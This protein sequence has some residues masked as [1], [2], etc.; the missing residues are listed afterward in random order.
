MVDYDVIFCQILKK[1]TLLDKN[2]V[3]KQA[4]QR[5]ILEFNAEFRSFFEL[6]RLFL[7]NALPAPHYTTETS[8]QNRGSA[9]PALQLVGQNRE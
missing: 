5:N 6:E 3:I 1:M 4:P 2:D 9:E 7:R 8:S